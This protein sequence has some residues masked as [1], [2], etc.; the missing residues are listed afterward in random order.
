MGLSKYQS[1]RDFSQ[2]S[3][4]GGDAPP[5]ASHRPLFVIQKHQA[6][7]LH[8]DFRLECDGV[9]KSWAVPKGPSADPSVK[10]L[11]VE[12]ED[13]PLAYE[14]FEG[15]IPR[16]QYG[17]GSVIVWDRGWWEP[18]GAAQT[19][20]TNGKLYFMLHG[21]R[22]R[23]RWRLVR[24]K[25]GGKQPQW[26][27]SKVDDDQA[28]PSL[29]LTKLHITSVLTG[30]ALDQVD[31]PLPEFIGLKLPSIVATP[32]SGKQWIHELKLDGYRM[33]ARWSS[34][35]FSLRTRG[36]GDWTT[37][38]PNLVTA[39]AKLQLSGTIM[40]GELTAV[41]KHGRSS[42]NALQS[43]SDVSATLAYFAFDLLYLHGCD[44]RQLPL[45]ERKSKLRQLLTHGS[46][47][48]CTQLQFLDHIQHDAAPLIAECRRLDLEGIVSKRVERP[49]ASGRAKDWLK[50]KERQREW[51]V[52]G[53]YETSSDKML[54]SILLGYYGEARASGGGSSSGGGE[55]LRFAGRVGTGWSGIQSQT[56]IAQ[57]ASRK[58][59]SR[60]FAKAVPGPRSTTA[61]VRVHW[62]KPELTAEVAFGGWTAAGVLRQASL[63][64]VSE[65]QDPTRITK[66]TVSMDS[67][68]VAENVV[69]D[70][71]E[72]AT[73]RQVT[74]KRQT[75]DWSA[76]GLTNQ[77]RL[78][79]PADGITK[80]DVAAYLYQVGQWLL[81]HVSNRPISLLR[82][83][84]GIE[85]EQ[86]FQR[87]PQ[88]GFPDQIGSLA[89]SDESK[90]LLVLKGLPAVLATAQISALE[91]HPWGCRADRLDRP[92]R[93]TIDLDPDE[94]LPWNRLVEAAMLVKDLLAVR[95]LVC[96]VK[97]TGGKGLHVVVPLARRTG[98]E[99]LFEYSK[100]LA[101]QLSKAHPR[102]F[103]ANMSK[104]KRRDR[105]Y[106]DYHRNRRGSTAVAAYSLR[107][108]PGATVSTPLTWDELP[109]VLPS[110]FTIRTLP[111]RLARL[112]GDPWEELGG[113]RQALSR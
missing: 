34:A 94:A 13:H 82:C 23:G 102:V 44:V 53:G 83:P 24:T 99:I 85:S 90:P 89:A 96:F 19:G 33:Q 38:Y 6:S 51:F 36:G 62:A 112:E 104:A 27:L 73:V 60:P 113:L 31:Q 40:D 87:H 45:L 46:A 35:G 4:P 25:S 30:R 32:P 98:W 88:K 65:S 52:I 22:V 12:V 9:L 63:V 21:Q 101:E 14:N 17:A 105:I 29:D 108:R 20:L 15:I 109:H 71:D 37:R 74:S 47:S 75:I 107:A 86:Y 50:Y 8:F 42:F 26:L 69:S 84:Q 100:S 55:E 67:S 95:G 10:R 81:P 103:V 18:E 97:T 48:K 76:L 110:Q 91:L 41:D 43:A 3:E 28:D 39:L 93:M 54:S 78:L 56:L 64:S 92:D 79:Y 80:A 16:G 70:V 11:A 111:E 66:H 49:Y 77:E 72:P 68:P 57:L 5:S 7:T 61:Q 58:T 2:T 1:K 59:R 106:V